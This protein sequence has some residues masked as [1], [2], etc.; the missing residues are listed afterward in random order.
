[1]PPAGNGGHSGQRLIS[2]SRTQLL[3]S[4]DAVAMVIAAA[5]QS[6][7][8]RLVVLVATAP[9]AASEAVRAAGQ[10]A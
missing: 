10:S 9:T 3:I 5:S 6:R 4:P 2:T 8:P 1:M 7:P